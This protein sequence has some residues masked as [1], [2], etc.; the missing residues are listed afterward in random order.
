MLICWYRL[1]TTGAM[2]KWYIK[3]FSSTEKTEIPRHVHNEGVMGWYSEFEV[4]APYKKLRLLREAG[5]AT[6]EGVYTCATR[7]ESVS[8]GISYPSKSVCI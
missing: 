4:R 1:L 3:D 6:V 2:F 7:E 8:V 5:T